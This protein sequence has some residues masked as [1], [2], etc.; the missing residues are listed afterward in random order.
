ME[1]TTAHLTAIHFLRDKMGIQAWDEEKRFF[2]LSRFYSPEPA[3]FERS[4]Q[5][6]DIELVN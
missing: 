1:K 3:L 4:F 2:L 5:L 6:N